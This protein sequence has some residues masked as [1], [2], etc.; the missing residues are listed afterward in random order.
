MARRQI[1]SRGID[2]G[3]RWSLP[4]PAVLLLLTAAGFVVWQQQEFFFLWTPTQA[5]RAMY[6]PF[7]FPESVVIADYL[8]RHTKPDQQIAVLGS[9]PEIYFYA[10]RR[11]ATSYITV[12]SL[13]TAQPSARKM[14]QE[15][16]RQI[17]AAQPEYLVYVNVRSSWQ[18]FPYNSDRFLLD[19]SQRYL[20]TY[21]RPVG[22]VDIVSPEF[23]DYRWDDRAVGAEPRSRDH[24]WIFQRKKQPDSRPKKD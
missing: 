6:G 2:G 9:E 10:Q 7:P 23:T 5:C 16:C 20:H 14:Q 13:M 1:E 12:Y 4:W 24:V 3:W 8:K 15:M 19:W 11:S 17:E 22:L 18:L 21:Y